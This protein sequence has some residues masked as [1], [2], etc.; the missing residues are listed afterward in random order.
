MKI[1]SSNISFD[2]SYSKTIF[3]KVLEEAKFW[4]GAQNQKKDKSAISV[5]TSPQSA[6]DELLTSQNLDIS[7]IDYTKKI[8]D[9]TIAS[10]INKNNA[11]AEADENE[12][13]NL[14]DPRLRVIKAIYEQ[15]TGKELDITPIADYQKAQEKV[16]AD[17]S[18][19]NSIGWSFEYKRKEIEAEAQQSHFSSEGKILTED[20]KEINFHLELYSDYFFSKESSTQI[21][22]SSPEK[23]DPLVINFNGKAAELSSIKFNFDIDADGNLDLIPML[24]RGSGYLA[25]DKNNDGLINS[26]AELFGPS[27]GNGFLELSEYDSD[28]NGWI[29]ENDPVFHNLKVWEKNADGKDTLQSLLQKNIGAIYLNSI[30]S[31]FELKSKENQLLGEIQKTG[32]YLNENGTVGTIQQLDLAV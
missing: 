27:T 17:N 29:D 13:D 26:G 30:N 3:K 16:A 21:V 11:S 7:Q 22:A 24:E 19:S 14:L 25:L 6:K 2:S 10:N 20:G 12:N 23:K 28:S 18:A 15:M 4:I 32:I 5:Q 1:Q 31:P 8:P 9:S